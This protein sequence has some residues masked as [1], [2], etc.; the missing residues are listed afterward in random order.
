[1]FRGSRGQVGAG[2]EERK[3]T[4][5]QFNFLPGLDLSGVLIGLL[6]S[7]SSCPP[8]P[9]G[10]LDTTVIWTPENSDW[11]PSRPQMH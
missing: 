4:Q 10:H 8:E 2:A 5:G 1:M 11:L 6:D 9:I 3:D 7:P